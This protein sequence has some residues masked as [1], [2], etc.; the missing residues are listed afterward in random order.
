MQ[1]IIRRESKW[2]ALCF[3]Y[4]SFT[5]N[6][7]RGCGS[8][9]G[10]ALALHSA[11]EG[12]TDLLQRGAGL[13]LTVGEVMLQSALLLGIVEQTRLQLGV[14][15]LVQRGGGVVQAFTQSLTK[16]H[17]PNGEALVES[18]PIITVWRTHSKN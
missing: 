10:H 1:S 15:V 5:T 7:A 13:R 3:V 18:N 17:K 14:V 12:R 2:P 4:L 16:Q 6:G 8:H 11:P 9:V